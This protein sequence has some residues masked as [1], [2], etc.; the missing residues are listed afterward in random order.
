MTAKELRAEL[1]RAKIEVAEFL[2]AKSPVDGTSLLETPTGL[3]N[4]KK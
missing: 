1:E 4:Q 3:V 2:G